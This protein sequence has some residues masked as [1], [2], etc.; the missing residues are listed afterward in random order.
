MA[1]DVVP[2]FMSEY[3]GQLAIGQTLQRKPGHAHDVA[4]RG[5]GVQMIEPAHVREQKLTEHCNGPVRWDGVSGGP[6]PGHIRPYVRPPA[7]G[8]IHRTIVFTMVTASAALEAVTTGPGGV[9]T[10]VFTRDKSPTLVNLDFAPT[11]TMPLA[12]QGLRPGALRGPRAGGPDAAR[13]HRSAHRGCHRRG[14]S[15]RGLRLL[16]PRT[17]QD[18]R[19]HE[20]SPEHG[21]GRRSVTADLICRPTPPGDLPALTDGCS[22]V[23][24]SVDFGHALWRRWR[25]R[26]L[27]SPP[28]DFAL[29]GRPPYMDRAL[30]PGT[31]APAANTTRTASASWH[32]VC[33]KIPRCLGGRRPVISAGDG[34]GSGTRAAAWWQCPR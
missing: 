17:G 33:S 3:R 13:H 18:L 21:S 28:Y 29:F 34:G 12:A 11:F 26:P 14:A 31:R 5:Q 7:A 30:A 24:S 25:R 10:S 4:C 23:F 8:E 19:H 1:A 9:L 16:D 27:R 22:T 2:Q 15:R 6:S 20:E 32:A